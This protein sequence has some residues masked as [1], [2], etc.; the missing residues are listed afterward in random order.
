MM[1]DMVEKERL[2]MLLEPVMQFMQNKCHPHTT[3]VVTSDN[4]ELMEGQHMFLSARWRS[5]NQCAKK[6]VSDAQS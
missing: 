4:A 3:V 1:L 5:Q 2:S 6:E